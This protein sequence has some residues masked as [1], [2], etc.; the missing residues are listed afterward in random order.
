MSK[1]TDDKNVSFNLETPNAYYV[2]SA[3]VQH[4][5]DPSHI[6]VMKSKSMR[7]QGKSERIFI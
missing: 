2:I 6:I 5:N 7:A 3:S 1:L 4:P